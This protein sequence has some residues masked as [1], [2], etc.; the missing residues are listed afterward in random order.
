[1]TT[2]TRT[3]QVIGQDRL[4]GRCT[5]P[6]WY[7]KSMGSLETIERIS[8]LLDSDMTKTSNTSMRIPTALREAAAL[9]AKE[10]NA[11]PSATALTTMALRSK[12]RSCVMSRTTSISVPQ[13]VVE[14]TVVSRGASNMLSGRPYLALS[15]RHGRR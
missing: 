15:H 4:P 7:D 6:T 9:A 5:T 13:I 10:L 12:R 8:Q 2:A 1:M 14:H 11:A 3:L